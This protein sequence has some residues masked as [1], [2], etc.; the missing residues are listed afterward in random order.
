MILLISF[1]A[2]IG[3]LMFKVILEVVEL[4]TNMRLTHTVNVCMMDLFQMLLVLI[5][6]FFYVVHPT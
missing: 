4:M 5:E 2:T 3:S 6:H 1:A